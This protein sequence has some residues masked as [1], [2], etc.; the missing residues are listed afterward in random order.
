MPLPPDFQ[1]G[2]FFFFEEEEVEDDTPD[3]PTKTL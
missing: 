3:E 2:D 1:A